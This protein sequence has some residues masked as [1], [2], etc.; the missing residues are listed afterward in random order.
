MLKDLVLGHSY[1]VSVSAVNAIGEG[2]KS[3]ALPLHTGVAPSKMMGPHA[4]RLS[5][6]S[7]TSITISW[8]PPSY[9]G[10]ASLSAY[11]VYHD[12]GQ[13]GTSTAVELADLTV[14]SWTL[15]AESSKDDAGL[16][17]FATGKLVDFATTSVNIIGESVKSDILTLYIAGVPSQPSKPT[18]SSVFSLQNGASYASELGI[19]VSWLAPASDAPIKGYKLFMA[20]EEDPAQLIFDGSSSSRA[21]VLTYTVREGITKSL[22]YKFTVQAVSAVGASLLS[23]ELLVPATVPPSA[24]LNLIVTASDAGSISLE[25]SA[26]QETGGVAISGYYFYYETT[27]DLTAATGVVSSTNPIF[28]RYSNSWTKSA[29]KVSEALAAS[30]LTGLTP[31]QLYRIRMVAE[32]SRGEGDFSSS[33]SQYA[34]AVPTQLAALAVIPASRAQTSLGISWAAPGISTTDVLGYRLYINEPSSNAIPTKL[35]YDGAAISNV[36]TAKVTGTISQMTYWFSYQ[37]RNRAG[38][39]SPSSPYLKVVAGPLP[40]PPASAPI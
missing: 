31:D 2:A 28:F 8:L 38:W 37:V 3:T 20:E 33:V 24:P 7:S 19:T 34:G 18:E 5:S 32:N 22:V 16:T 35:V 36:L 39:S 6:S 15:N 13:T 26:P 9:N 1:E 23:S 11:R 14:T 21:D 12:I 4:P 30:V 17:L 27:A 40:S 10:G 25:W 29:D